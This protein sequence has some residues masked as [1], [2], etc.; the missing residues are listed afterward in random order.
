MKKKIY[1]L[2][3]LFCA[4]L[5][6]FPACGMDIESSIKTITMPYV[7]EYE[8]VEARLG[9]EDLLEKYEYFYI[10]LVNKEELEISFKEKDGK[11]TLVKGTYTI[12]PKTRELT[13][14]TGVLGFR[15][16]DSVIVKNGEF[17]IE[18]NLGPFPLYMKFKVR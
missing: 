18:K 12:D 1:L 10:T 3:L 8:C 11:R 6:L 13:G 15:F 16:K 5:L 7:A 2:T 17:V 4:V 14:E 9:S